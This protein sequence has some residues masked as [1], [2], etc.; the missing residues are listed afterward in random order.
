MQEKMTNLGWVVEDIV[1]F[2]QNGGFSLSQH[3][4]PLWHRPADAARLHCVSAAAAAYIDP[5]APHCALDSR[6]SPQLKRAGKS[7]MPAGYLRQVLQLL[8]CLALHHIHAHAHVALKTHSHALGNLQMMCAS[9]QRH[10]STGMST[11]PS[12]CGGALP[13]SA[14]PPHSLLPTAPSAPLTATPAAAATPARRKGRLCSTA[15]GYSQA[16]A[17]AVVLLRLVR[18]RDARG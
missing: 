6:V 9:S 17:D 8:S 10:L 14:M 12:G 15:P 5:C 2:L 13:P 11:A 7:P 3:R 4:V 18:R 1:P 16:A